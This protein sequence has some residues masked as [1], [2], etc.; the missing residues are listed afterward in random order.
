[1][2]S[3]QNFELEDFLGDEFFI[4]WVLKPKAEHI[5]FWESWLLQHPEKADIVQRSVLTIQSLAVKPGCGEFS[6]Q[7]LA[8]I[9]ENFEEQT[10]YRPKA[11]IGFFS[12]SNWKWVAAAAI[13]LV[14][15]TL[16]FYSK[17]NSSDSL[18]VRTQGAHLSVEEDAVK[19]KKM[20]KVENRSQQSQLFVLSDGSVVILKPKSALS[21]H[22]EFHGPNREVFLSGEAFFDVKKNPA[23][24]FLVHTGNVI[25][26]VLGTSFTIRAYP[27]VNEFK[28]LVN[29]GKVRV[30]TMKP[31]PAAEAGINA[32]AGVTLMPDEQAMLLPNGSGF[33]KTVIAAVPMLSPQKAARVFAFKDTPLPQIIA[34]LEE[35]YGVKIDYDRSK[36]ADAR[37]TASLSELPLT[38]KI[39]AICTAIDASY[40]FSTEGIKIR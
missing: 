33:R 32:V 1:M 21:Y 34:R 7:D 23:S 2:N 12:Y 22:E 24:P 35:A 4:E 3:Y 37:I 39:R 38:D 20:V 14:S 13:V 40:V 17:Y 10:A 15:L 8:T 9:I 19:S 11:S 25:T 29:T 18:S 5:A 30:F 26:K 27:G 28:V 16:I 6:D 31:A 36:Y